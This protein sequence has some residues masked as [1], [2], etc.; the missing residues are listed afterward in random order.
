MLFQSLGSLDVVSDTAIPIHSFGG[1]ITV[2]AQSISLK[3]ANN[4]VMVQPISSNSGVVSLTASG[5][6]T[7]HSEES[8]P[9]VA[10]VFDG[11]TASAALS[12]EANNITITSSASGVAGI[13][14]YDQ[15]NGGTAGNGAIAITVKAKDTL[16]V[17]ETA[18][19]VLLQRVSTANTA[20][21]KSDISAGKKI[22]IHADQNALRLTTQTGQISSTVDAPVIDIASNNASAVHLNNEASLTFGSE[23]R[24]SQIS[25]SSPAGQNAVKPRV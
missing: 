20:T 8:S 4:A 18:Y 21:I 22:S 15:Y 16:S 17:D 1:T 6:I 25:I 13:S 14:A 10:A 24:P 11:R 19:G 23:T 5:D 3:S 7:I 12:L 2:E 9:V